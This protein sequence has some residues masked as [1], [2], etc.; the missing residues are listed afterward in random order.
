MKPTTHIFLLVLLLAMQTLSGSAVAAPVQLDESPA[1]GEEWGFRPDNETVSVDPPGFSWRPCIGA[2]SYTVEVARD[3]EFKDI[4]Y[5][6]DA[7]PW[8]AHCPAK[9]LGQGDYFWRYRACD[10]DGN[11]SAWSQ[12]RRFTVPPDAVVFPQPSRDEL[13]QRMPHEHPRLFF[14]GEDIPRLH[15]QAQGPLAESW[16]ALVRTADKLIASPPDTSDPPRYPKEVDRIKTP[17]EWKKIWWGNRARV[18]AVADGAATLAFVYRVSGEERYGKAARDLLMAT[19]AWDL[20]GGT[21]YGYNDEAAM[22][23]LYMAARAYS[24]S[25]PVL[26]ESDRAAVAAM[27]RER[28]GQ[29]YKHLRAR[30]HLW[31]PYDS[32]ANRA[33]HF[34][35]E[36]AIAFYDDIPEAPEWL[37]Y[38]MTKFYTAY[39]VWGDDDGGWHE[40][41]AYWNSYLSLFMYW[42]SIMSSEFA[43]DVFQKPFFRHAGDFAL[44]TLPPGSET[45]AFGDLALSSSSTRLAPLMLLLA[46]GSRNSYWK[47]YADCAEANPGS[48]YLGFLYG[49]QLAGLEGKP[50]SDLPSSRCFHGT[51]LAVMN[52][53]LLDGKNNIQIDFK[54]SPFGRQSH[55]FN[56]NN[57]FMLNVNGERALISSGNRDLYGSKHHRNWMWETRSDNAILVN[58]Q[59][60]IPHTS[61]ARGRISLF[62]T[63]PTVDVVAGEAAESYSDVQR[64]TRRILFLKPNVIVIHDVLDTPEPATFDW[65]LHGMAP[66]SIE[67]QDVR[68]E[69]AASK[70]HLQFLEPGQLAIS[71]TD[72]MDPPP[73]DYAKLKWKEWHLSA[74]ST[75]K[76]QH[77]EFVVV[78]SLQGADAAATYEQGTP[79]RVRLR[80]GDSTADVF[81]APDEFKIVTPGYEKTF[82][83]SK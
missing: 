55:G 34:L 45:G 54:S 13:K 37:D 18:I 14:R 41:A 77:R 17:G 83:A 44:Y 29:A 28:G 2:K 76:A 71:Q 49:M 20:K 53:N 24:W 50:P 26:S 31:H 52:T 21:N 62:D 80:F 73:G 60:Q 63:S 30:S 33:W 38:A 48:G 47:W 68:W 25:Y 22:P 66:F 10:A 27:M 82:P 43:I 79:G 61:K 57:A 64:W 75:E 1:V 7:V 6:S 81:L 32:H 70:G 9:P 51:G 58:G 15:E 11:L 4:A 69:G 35:G 42:A 56:S 5:T 3:A 72:V 65:L 67:G 78:I 39:P 8:S 74:Q 46:N 23:M 12:T 19:T 40:G 16:A 36:T 59:G